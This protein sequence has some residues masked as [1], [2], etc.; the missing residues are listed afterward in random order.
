MPTRNLP[1]P[2][3]LKIVAL[4]DERRVALEG[5]RPLFLVSAEALGKRKHRPQNGQTAKNQDQ[6]PAFPP[7]ARRGRVVQSGWNGERKS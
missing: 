7:K 1:L 4:E 5:R 2:Y 6:A 3:L